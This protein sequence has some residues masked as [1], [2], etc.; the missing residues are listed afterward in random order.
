LDPDDGAA[1]ARWWERAGEPSRA[2]RLYREALPWLEGG[3]DWAWAAARS[4]ALEKRWGESR[5]SVALW[6][7]LWAQGDRGAAL[8][9]AKHF[10]HRVRDLHA[11][12]EVTQALLV[13]PEDADRI[14]LEHRLERLRRKMARTAA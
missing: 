7:S 9:L 6:H 2:I 12:A 5:R 10:E 8:E 4:A 11:A 3:D 14:A 13:R 1:V